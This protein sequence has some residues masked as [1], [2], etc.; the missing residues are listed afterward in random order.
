MVYPLAE[1][2]EKIAEKAQGR[3][4]QHQRMKPNEPDAKE[5]EGRHSCPSV[6]VGIGDDKTGETE[7]E[8]DCQVG[9]VQ[10][11]QRSIPA[12]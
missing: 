6:I 11:A 12:K 10:Q 3:A 9:V 4:Y 8:I 2:I 7:E 1:R 5:L